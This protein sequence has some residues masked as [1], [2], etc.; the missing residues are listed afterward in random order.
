MRKKKMTCV[1][2]VLDWGYILEIEVKISTR[3]AIQQTI[4]FYPH[5]HTKVLR[6]LRYH[7][8]QQVLDVAYLWWET[9]WSLHYSL[10]YCD[11]INALTAHS[12]LWRQH[13]TFC[14]YIQRNTYNFQA[15]GL[16]R[17]QPPSDELLSHLQGPRRTHKRCYLLKYCA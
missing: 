4:Y 8:Q 17:T 11:L 13:S 3:D 7:E 2:F 14:F 10:S 5:N 1:R 9:I 12:P 6:S 15:V 16:V